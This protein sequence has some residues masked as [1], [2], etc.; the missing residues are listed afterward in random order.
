MPSIVETL[1]TRT[2]SAAAWLNK[3][4]QLVAM[5]LRTILNQV[6]DDEQPG[7]DPGKLMVR[8][9]LVTVVLSL[10]SAL[11]TF[12]ILT[13]LTPI[14][15]RPEVVVGALFLNVS[16]IIAMIIIV[17]SQISGLVRAWREKVAGAR[18]HIRIVGLFSLI[19]ALPAI[20][21][22][23]A[24]TVSF[25]RSLDNWFS[26]RV[27]AIID[28]SVDVARTYV[29]EHS[30]VIRTDIVNMTRDVNAAADEV[31]K[32]PKRLKEVI[33]S[34][35][36]LRDLPSA[37]LIDNAGKREL[38]ALE[39]QKLPFTLPTPAAIHEAEAGQIPLSV[40]MR[41]H[42]ISAIA[43]L[44]A[45]PGKYLYVSRGI[46]PTVLRHLDQTERNAAEYTALRR[47]RGGL[48]WAHGLMYL[49]ISMTALLAAIW[50]GMWFAGRFV[51]PIRRLIA[52][53]QEVSTGNLQ[54]ALP[55][56]RGEGDLRR[57]SQTF[58]TMTRE[59]KHQRDALVTANEQLEIRRR[60]ME[61]V[62]SGVSAGVIGLDSQDRITLVS[63]SACELLGVEQDD[64]VGKP[65]TVALPELA[66]VLEKSNEPNL[67]ARPQEQ[68]STVVEGEE[69]TYAVR[70][71]HEKAGD[72]DV[73]SVV[74]F[75]DVTELVVAQRTSAW[76]DVA[77]RIAHEI[78]NPLTPIQLSAER[79]RR[80]Y[81]ERIEG[82]R[83]TF[84]K[85]TETIER[86]AGHIKGMVDEF[87]AFARMPKP[88]MNPTDVRDAVQEAVLLFRE[89]HPNIEYPL[90]IPRAP[91]SSLLDRRLI[92]QAVTNLVKNA[93]EAIETAAQS[94]DKPADWHGRVT[95][96]VRP[97]SDRVHIEVIDNGTGLPRQN[98]TRLL[99]PYVTTKGHKGTGLGL[100]MVQKITEQHGGTLT[101]EDAACVTGEDTTGAVVR[102]TLP[103]QESPHKTAE[104][105]GSPNTTDQTE[106]P[107]TTSG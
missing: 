12:L 3:H 95:T 67:K 27:R 72:Q 32:D 49:T 66:Q 83:E 31:S 47:A 58:N 60:F 77:R 69:R 19:A 48:K 78:K 44:D 82:D 8:V 39:D 93:T 10:I 9:G 51:A 13:G 71:T 18:L 7:L 80:K 98:R 42:R 29:A 56:K 45:F 53:A 74:T 57:L 55:E 43:K 99:E 34:Q 103:L 87:A 25:A 73:G 91:I 90:E 86:Q 85:L 63:R 41:D 94:G 61:A 106:S 102:I 89:A 40:S 35:A 59:L 62:L 21:L 75:D 54:V 79:L 23:I 92:S 5:R 104:S 101:L 6:G 65:F 4:T 1:R 14:V 68:I 76:A 37:F 28:N 96:R 38:T 100:A 2:H 24:A 84:N 20:L 81:G 107:A 16:L 36:A 50:A 22:A 105:G 30:Q 70:I 52:A 88:E 17:A 64:L 15:P 33:L 11:L 26:D 46:S 97:E